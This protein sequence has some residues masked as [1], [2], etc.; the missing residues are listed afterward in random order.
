MVEA[1]AELRRRG[2]PIRGTFVGE[3]PTRPE[4]EQAAAAAG[5]ADEITFA[6]AV[7]QD[8]MHRF[9]E[10]ADVFCMSSF[11]EGL[12]VVLIEAMAMGL[13]VVSTNISAIPELV[14]DGVSGLLVPPARADLIVG[15]LERLARDP[16]LRRAMGRAGR[17]KVAA[18]FDVHRSAEELHEIFSRSLAS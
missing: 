5:I 10:R 11:A 4:V 14:E 18:A 3:G 6:G 9:Y 16:E 7:A 13:P 1:I 12:P 8:E 2:I 17:S 15:A